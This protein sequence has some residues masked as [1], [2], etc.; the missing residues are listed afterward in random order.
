MITYAGYKVKIIFI[1]FLFLVCHVVAYAEMGRDREFCYPGLQKTIL[2]Q[3]PFFMILV[4]L[5]FQMLTTIQ[6]VLFYHLKTGK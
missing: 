4:Q 3:R 1:I 5:L 2:P 6:P